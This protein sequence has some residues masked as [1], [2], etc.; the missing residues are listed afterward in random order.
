[1][2]Y[3]D[4]IN[5]WFKEIDQEKWW[6]KNTEFDQLIKSRF[7]N[8]HTKAANQNLS[9]WRET[10]LGRLAE[11]IVLDQFSRNMFRDTP[12]SFAYDSLALKLAQ[13]A[14]N[15]GANKEL[16]PIQQSFLYLPFMHSESKDMHE[17][18]VILFSE[19]GLED[20]L[21]FEHM[22]KKIID[23]FGR[24]PHRNAILGR[25]STTEEIE[26]LKQPGSSF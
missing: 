4:I 8:T 17:K 19:P 5:F 26:F 1:M 11:V 2:N 20:N 25:E 21:K 12:K 10:P 22:H 24:Y 16:P 13:E 9:Q 14:I 23:K 15:S 3:Q 18:A 7:L 6:V